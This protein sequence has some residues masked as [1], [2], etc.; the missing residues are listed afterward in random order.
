MFYIDKPTVKIE[1]PKA[2]N[3]NEKLVVNCTVTEAEPAVKEDAINWYYND[4]IR[5]DTGEQLEV[6]NIARDQNGKYSCQAL[7][8]VDKSNRDEC[9]IDVYCECYL[10]VIIV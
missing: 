4:T 2:V 8:K 7:N 9:S 10:L 3:E 1:C 6:E 5:D